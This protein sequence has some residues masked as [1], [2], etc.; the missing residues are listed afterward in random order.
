MG[1][2]KILEK[3]EDMLK[4]YRVFPKP[5]GFKAVKTIEEAKAILKQ[6]DN[7]EIDI[8]TLRLHSIYAPITVRNYIL[9]SIYDYKNVFKKWFG[10]TIDT[11]YTAP[12]AARLWGIDE[13]TVKK[14]CQQGRFTEEEARKSGGTWL[15]TIAGMERVYGQKP[16]AK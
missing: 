16:D 4:V 13:S 7:N 11:I 5:P 14:A 3:G 9:E 15:V 8:E 1:K 2:D 12:E 6:A 10:L